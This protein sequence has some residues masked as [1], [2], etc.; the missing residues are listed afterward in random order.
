MSE[1]DIQSDFFSTAR[2]FEMNFARK[3]VIESEIRL[4]NR[5]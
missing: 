2:R 5:H 4:N 1:G 3:F